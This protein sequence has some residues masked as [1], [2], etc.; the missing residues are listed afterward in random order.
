MVPQNKATII[1]TALA[2]IATALATA[3]TNLGMPRTIGVVGALWGF[4]YVAGKYLEGVQMF[5]E[6]TRAGVPTEELEAEESVMPP[7]M[8]ETTNTG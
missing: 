4:V 1:V 7:G 3:L 2:S 8:T 5:E 6:R